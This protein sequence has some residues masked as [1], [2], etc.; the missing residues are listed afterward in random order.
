MSN[1]FLGLPLWVWLVI[2]GMIAYNCYLTTSNMCGI[3]PNKATTVPTMNTPTLSG[4]KTPS[5][6]V[7]NEYFENTS[8]Y[9][10]LV[11][12]SWCG[13][14]NKF[15]PEWQKFK[16]SYKGSYNALDFNVANTNQELANKAKEVS[17]MLGV[18]GFPSIFI[19]KDGNAT[20][21]NGERTADALIKALQ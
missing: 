4:S 19:V 14:S 15:I 3:L 5:D 13:W 7:V 18:K 20:Q 6:I 11:W 21:Y 2:I 1:N 9:V 16:N 12:A 10:V 8:N 17:D